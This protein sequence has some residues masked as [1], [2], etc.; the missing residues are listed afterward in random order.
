MQ[1]ILVSFG[2][3]STVCCLQKNKQPFSD[4]IIFLTTEKHFVTTDKHCDY[5]LLS[6]CIWKK[7]KKTFASI[8]VKSIRFP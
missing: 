6:S 3:K 8:A 7:K 5:S 4:L 2:K 1:I